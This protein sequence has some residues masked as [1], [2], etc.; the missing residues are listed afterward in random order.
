MN[1]MASKNH[2]SS[3]VVV[4]GNPGAADLHYVPALRQAGWKMGVHLVSPG[5]TLPDLAEA[6]G[7]LL[8][9]GADMHPTAWD[10]EEGVHPTADPAPARDALEIPL[11]RQAWELGLPVLGICRGEQVLNVALGGSLFQHV[12]EAYACPRERHQHGHA[13]QGPDLRHR[14]RVAE[15]SRLAEALGTTDLPV[16]SRHHQAVRRVAPVLRAV[17]WDDATPGPGGPLVEG[18]ESP[19]PRHWVL[20]VQWHPE[21]LVGL[22]GA[23]GL[24][25][26]NLF[27]AFLAAV[28]AYSATAGGR[29]RPQ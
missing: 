13:D 22:E 1:K 24:A 2:V 29:S 18:V 6:V 12:P 17:A 25:A 9:G 15:G 7:L 19:D 21:N 23:G 14:V 11:V 27:Q 16:N 3:I 26:R 10:P 4:C 20:G 8:C 5:E 28:A